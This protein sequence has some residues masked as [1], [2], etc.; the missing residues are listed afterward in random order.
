MNMDELSI[1]KTTSD[2]PSSSF[3]NVVVLEHSD[4][5]H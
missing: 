2:T 3:I 5:Q 1:D 4:N